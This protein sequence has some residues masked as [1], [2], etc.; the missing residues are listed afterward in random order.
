MSVAMAPP[1]RPKLVLLGILTKMPVGGVFWQVAHYIVGFRRLGYDVYYVEAHAGTPKMLMGHENDDATARAVEFLGQRMR[2]LGMWD[3]WAFHALHDDGGCYGMSWAELRRLYR[4][5]ALIINLHG[6]TKPLDEHAETGRLVYLETDPVQLQVELHRGEQETVDFLSPHVAFFTSALNYGNPTCKLPWSEHFP[7]V[8]SPPP[9]VLDEWLPETSE[10]TAFTTIGNWRQAWRE[11][12]FLGETYTWS[13]HHEFLKVLDLPERVRHP[14]L[15]ALSSFEPSDREE[16]ERHGWAVS[17][18]YEMSRDPDAY[19][20]FIR[21]SRG[22]FSVAKDQNVRLRTGWFSERS[23]TYLAAGRPVIVQ[24][25]GFGDALPTG[26]G[27]FAFSHADEAA[28]AIEEAARDY[29]RHRNAAQEIARTYL[30]SDVVLGALLDHVGA[31]RAGRGTRISRSDPSRQHAIPDD[32]VLTPLSRRPLR[33]PEPTVARV[34]ALPVPSVPRTSQDPAFSVVVVTHGG[35]VVTRLAVESL[36]R[37]ATVGAYE[38]VVV[39]NASGA[40]TLQ[41]LRVVAARNP[42]VRLI[43]NRDNRGFAA[44]NNQGIGVARGA[45]VILLN[46]DTIVPPGALETLCRHAADRSVGLV[47]PVTNRCGNEA[48]VRIDYDTYGELLGAVA[49]RPAS[50]V[51]R[52]IPV[53]VMFCVAARRDVLT[54]V[55]PLDERF[56]VGMFEDDDYA[57]RVRDA[58][59]RVVCAEEAFVHHFGE[60]S[61]GALVPDGRYAQVFEENR[62][63]FERKWGVEWHPHDHRRDQVY[64]D[65][66]A[67]LRGVLESVVPRGSL[68]AVVSHGDDRLVQTSSVTCAHFPAT[69]TGAHLGHHPRDAA[70]ALTRLADAQRGGVTHLALPAASSWWLTHYRDLATHLE[71]HQVISSTEA[72]TVWALSGAR[73]VARQVGA[74]ERAS[75]PSTRVTAKEATCPSR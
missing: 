33:L 41:Y 18:G 43:E 14:L 62:S 35:P 40:E 64:E 68:V 56:G 9:V 45:V 59:L 6:A 73:T 31:P 49:R 28:V 51:V 3:R 44:A 47:G 8:P 5:A 32:L 22:E 16:L 61:F 37:N 53:A 23:A 15:L 4:E 48:E 67:A 46:N 12:Q 50:P 38:L 26:E 72:G 58:G 70:E 65:Q 34:Q 7:A 13:K 66:V 71:G 54:R 57:R 29:P 39:D 42:H 55:G 1:T 20:D 10:G 25:T 69:E 2:R 36:L 17:P 63:L 27:L 19:R 52:D 74:P 75:A 30:D 11:V 24:D 60:A 21:A